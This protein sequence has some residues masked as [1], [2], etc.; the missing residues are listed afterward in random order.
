MEPERGRLVRWQTLTVGLMVAGYTGY[1]LCRSNLAVCLPLIQRDLAA[2]G[3]ST[4]VTLLRLGQIV[5][6]GTAAYSLGKFF[7]GGLTDVFG[8]RTSYLAGMA[9]AVLFTVAFALGGSL[10]IFTL[11]WFGNRLVQSIGW[12]GMVK[13]VGRWFSY[14]T[15][16]AVMG[17]VSLSYLF[18]DAASRWFM[19]R[20]LDAGLGW[21]GVFFVAA[22]T[23]AALLVAN[24]LLIR[25]SPS[26]LGLKEPAANPANV[27]GKGGEE[28]RPP[29]VA[30]LFGPL[31]RSPAFWLV[32]LLSMG[33]TLLR[34]SF[35]TWTNTYFVKGVGLTAAEAAD[36]SAL[37]PL[38]GGVSVIVCGVLSDRLGR[39]GRA[40]L[41]L[42]GLLLAGGVL[43]TLGT[44]NLGGTR[45]WP[46]GMVAAVGFLLVGPYSFLAG[47]IALDFGGKRGGATASGLVDGFGYIGGVA[48][49]AGVAWVATARG[50]AGVFLAM[51]AVAWTSAAVAAVF[52]VQQVR[53]ARKVH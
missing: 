11:A 39:G 2:R 29:S 18:G 48:A 38:L 22:G 28:P 7:S 41:I 3:L 8:G 23:L 25:E 15:Y 32:C 37:F 16:G 36:A 42:L 27:F 20:L 4:E 13:I 24:L 14:S 33:L 46:I 35:N 43:A 34:E 31:L 45:A 19:G 49:G 10:P 30:V 17:V 26:R 21:R 40:S 12:P 53:D 6:L 52:L 47:A 50:W 5:S 1:Y 51:A 44:A 9:G